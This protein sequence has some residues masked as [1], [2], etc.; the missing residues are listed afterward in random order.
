MSACQRIRVGDV[1]INTVVT[2]NGPPLL[3]LHGCPQTHLIWRKVLPQ[4]SRSFTVV[5][6][7]LRGRSRPCG[8]YVPEEAPEALIDK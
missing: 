2:G 7:D 1:E 5:A 6:T 4:L 8:H 3:R